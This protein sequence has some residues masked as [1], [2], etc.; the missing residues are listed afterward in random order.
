VALPPHE[1]PE[2]DVARLDHARYP[3]LA[4]QRLD[5]SHIEGKIITLRR[6]G[7]PYPVGFER[8]AADDLRAQAERIA[9][10]L[11]LAGMKTGGDRESVAIIAYLQRLGRDIKADTGTRTAEH[12][13]ESNGAR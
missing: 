2:G 11:Q 7:V 5:T 6:L 9:A 8:R 10:G 4:T 3:W 1:R 13:R 12:L